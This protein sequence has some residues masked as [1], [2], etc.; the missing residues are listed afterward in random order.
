MA[1]KKKAHVKKAHH[2]EPEPKMPHHKDGGKSAMKAKMASGK[3]K[4]HK[5]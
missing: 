3:S 1:H 5:D 4:H 2:K